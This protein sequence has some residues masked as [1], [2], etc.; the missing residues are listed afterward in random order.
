MDKSA[1]CGKAREYLGTPF[2]QQ[3]R[4][5]HVG[6]DCVG[7]VLCTGEELGLRYK[8]GRLIHANDYL[9][10]GWF[11][12]LDR[13]QQEAIRV[14]EQKAIGAIGS[15]GRSAINFAEIEPGDIL[16]IRAP[17]QVHHMAIV[18]DLGGSL[19][20]IHAYGS[21]GSVAEHRLDRCWLSRIA[22]VF[23]YSGLDS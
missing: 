6:L 1:I 17:F 5:K 3:G 18:S 21:M 19:G 13:L 15:S 10:Y 4:Q 9:N 2:H 12:E 23:A 22:G 11:P 16:T 8:D 20:I 7:I 14:F